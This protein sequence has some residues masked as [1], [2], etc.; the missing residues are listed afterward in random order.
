MTLNFCASACGCFVVLA[1]ACLP[2]TSD[3]DGSASSGGS[4]GST[5]GSAGTSSGGSTGETTAPTTG[6]TTADGSS[7][8][9]TTIDPTEGPACGLPPLPE[10]VIP[11][12]GFDV[13]GS[14]FEMQPGE[15]RSLAIGA[16]ECCYVLQPVEACVTYAVTPDDGGAS[17]GPDTGL[18]TI[19]E[20][21]APG[22]VYTVTANVEDGRK[23]LEA[24]VY[25]W[26]PASNPL[27]GLWHEVAQ[28][29]CGDGTEA[30]PVKPIEELWI[31][32][33][34]KMTVTWTPFEIY[35]D[36]WAMYVFDL[37]TGAFSFSGQQGN[38][39]PVDIDA[40]GTF[41]LE[42]NDLVLKDMW[43]GAPQD[44]PQTPGCGHR[45]TRW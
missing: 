17:I 3:T 11:N 22:S 18:L 40:E 35:F 15:L 16:V 39:V 37:M 26:T 28:V 36:Y 33:S 5:G 31:R 13:F 9:G 8:G 6:S 38:Y 41:V 45:F 23:V 21:A 2:P 29:S 14:D 32:A 19:A 4:S 25:V 27:V 44:V 34:G 7:S 1:L 10:E 42:G 43:L 12:L 20:D 24:K 30:P